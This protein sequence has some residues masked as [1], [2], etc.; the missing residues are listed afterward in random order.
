MALKAQMRA[1]LVCAS[2]DLCPRHR[3][4]IGAGAIAAASSVLIA[5]QHPPSELFHRLAALVPDEVL[6]RVSDTAHTLRLRLANSAYMKN[7]QLLHSVGF[8]RESERTLCAD[9]SHR[10]AVV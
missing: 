4:S 5:P 9:V 7:Q 10:F 1:S 8:L 2:G 3:L 6:P